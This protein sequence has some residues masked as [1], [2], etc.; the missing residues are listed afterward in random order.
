[1]AKTFTDD[2]A[3]KYLDELMPG[4]FRIPEVMVRSIAKSKYGAEKDESLINLLFQHGV[5]RHDAI[6]W[7]ERTPKNVAHI[8][9]LLKKAIE[10]NHDAYPLEVMSGYRF[11]ESC[12]H[13]AAKWAYLSRAVEVARAID[14]AE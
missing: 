1:M 13:G 4:C 8:T 9:E 11:A 14:A 7:V 10:Q 5:I 12:Q 3:H 6:N 2:D